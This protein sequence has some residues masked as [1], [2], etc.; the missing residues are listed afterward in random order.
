[1]AWKTR[2]MISHTLNHKFHVSQFL[3][4]GYTRLAVKVASSLI[5][6]I[7]GWRIF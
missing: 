1:M 3:E 2:I 5:I 7:Y 6:V 4:G